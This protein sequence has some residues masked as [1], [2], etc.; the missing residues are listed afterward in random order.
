[1]LTVRDPDGLLLEFGLFVVLSHDSLKGDC[2]S[3]FY[4]HA[5]NW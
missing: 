3:N 5:V 1:M 2:E 4:A